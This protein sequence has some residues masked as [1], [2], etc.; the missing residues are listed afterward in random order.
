VANPDEHGISAKNLSHALCWLVFLDI[1]AS[2]GHVSLC[3][4]PTFSIRR[5]RGSTTISTGLHL[6]AA[7][8][9][10]ITPATSSA[11]QMV[12]HNL[13]LLWSIKC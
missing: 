3:A 5:R 10:I 12:I 7:V 9:T 6:T 13:H 11:L 1:S 2:S 8:D 4:G